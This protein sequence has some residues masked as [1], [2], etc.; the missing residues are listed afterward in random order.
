MGPPD[1]EVKQAQNFHMACSH[2]H[3]C[4]YMVQKPFFRFK[5][6]SKHL[7]LFHM[8]SKTA[9]TGF[10]ASLNYPL[11]SLSD[12]FQRFSKNWLCE[13]K[14]NRKNKTFSLLTIPTVTPKF[15][16]RFVCFLVH[17]LLSCWPRVP[18]CTNGVISIVDSIPCVSAI[19][20]QVTHMHLTTKIGKLRIKAV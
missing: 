1:D 11:T 2:D 8:P 16:H 5:I 6:T 15:R 7:Q 13:M 19:L 9:R 10:Q 14:C 18:P 4:S 12:K 3:V 20:I 17:S